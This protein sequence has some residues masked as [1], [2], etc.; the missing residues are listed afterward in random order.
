MLR[1]NRSLLILFGIF[2]FALAG[3]P[4]FAG[5]WAKWELVKLLVHSKMLFALS[6]ILLGSLFEIIFLFRWFTL[7]VKSDI[8]ATIPRWDASKIFS[9]SFLGVIAIFFAAMIMKVYYGFSLIHILPVLAVLVIDI[10]D[11]LP[12][13][14]KGLL[15]LLAVLAYGYYI[16][17]FESN[18]QL[19]FGI[20]FIVGSAVNI[21]ST[22]NRTGKSEG[23]YG[24]LL[25]MIFSFGNLIIATN[26]L[27]FFLTWEFMTISSFLLILRGKQAQKASLMYMIFSTAGA[28]LMMVGFAFAPQLMGNSPLVISLANVQLP[29]ISII[30]LSIG[31]MIKSGSLGVH[32]WLPEAHAEAEADVSSFISAILLKAGV[33]GLLLVGISYVKFAPSFDIF[34]WVGWIG[35]LT[36]IVGAF[37]ASFQEDAK[38]LLAYSSMSQVGYIVAAIAMVSHLGWVSALYLAF[39]HM[40]FKSALFIAVAGIYYRTHTRNMYEM[41]GLIKKCLCLILLFLS[42][43]LLFQVCRHYLVLVRNGLSILHSSQMAGTYKPVCYSLHQ[44]L[45]SSTFTESFIRYSWGS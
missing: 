24:F 8:A 28:Y 2:L 41:G 17:P 29:L 32:I 14:V 42:L 37:L 44:Q 39:N 12:S 11:F 22:L 26:Y 27:E 4:P 30:L 40:M 1:G 31:F 33:F 6:A 19:F 5:F 38:R 23:F 34:Y 35:V 16:Y 20:I 45:V 9:T 43:L 36:A 25:M 7:T 3:I 21:I 18:I 15:S 10:I 13:K